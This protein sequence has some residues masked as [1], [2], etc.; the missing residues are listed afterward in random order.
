MTNVNKDLLNVAAKTIT[1][2]ATLSR[3][4]WKYVV[5]DSGGDVVL[6]LPNSSDYTNKESFTVVKISTNA[7]VTSVSGIS[8]PDTFKMTRQWDSLTVT[9]TGSAWVITSFTGPYSQRIEIKSADFTAEYG[10]TYITYAS[11]GSIVVTDPAPSSGNFFTVINGLG[12]VTVGG[13]AYPNP[14]FHIDR[15][16]YGGSWTSWPKA[17]VNTVGSTSGWV[18]TSTG[19]GTMPTFQAPTGGG[20]GTIDKSC[21]LRKSAA[22]S[23]GVTRVALDFDV[24]DFDTDTMHSTVSNTSRITIQTPGKYLLLGTVSTSANATAQAAFRVNGTTEILLSAVGNA[25][26]SLNGGCTIAAIYSFTAGQ[27]VELMGAFGSTQNC[28]FGV[29]GCQFSASLIGVSGSSGFSGKEVEASAGILVPGLIGQSSFSSSGTLASVSV[30]VISTPTGV[31]ATVDIRMARETSD[32]TASTDSIFTSDAPLAIPL[33]VA[34]TNRARTSNV[35]TLTVASHTYEVGDVISVTLV[36][37]T[38]YNTPRATIT[39]KSG[40]TISYASTGSNEG[41]TADTA[42]RIDPK[43]IFKSTIDNGAF[44]SG[45]VANVFCVAAGTSPAVIGPVTIA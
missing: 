35:A 12:S 19:D 9:S 14:G 25:G 3:E 29:D 36:G 45:N 18:L 43:V 15:S 33:Q 21:R 22:Q 11:S 38:G 10:K 24:E 26:A 30:P 6:T 23:I 37:G 1:S 13:V 20:G 4:N 5:D 40:T 34:T 16:S 32:G 31:P 39:A 8:G 27:Y 17:V 42:G 28:S 44:L 7:H 2:S 41:T